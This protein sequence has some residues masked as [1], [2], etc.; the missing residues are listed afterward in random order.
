MVPEPGF[1]PGPSF[2]D[3]I[4]RRKK[5]GDESTFYLFVALFLYEG[6]GQR[7]YFTRVMD[8]QVDNG[9]LTF[10]PRY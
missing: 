7:P 5:R 9:A 1:E 2:E 10:V 8:T 3:G 4:L 6:Y